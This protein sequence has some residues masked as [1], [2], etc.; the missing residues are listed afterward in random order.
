MN[1]DLIP[2]EP[3]LGGPFYLDGAPVKPWLEGYFVSIYGDNILK[4]DTAGCG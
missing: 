4:S 3:H 2:H 1:G